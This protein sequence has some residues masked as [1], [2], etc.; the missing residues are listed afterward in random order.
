MDSWT[1]YEIT[2]V[3]M[4]CQFRER[5]QIGFKVEVIRNGK[6]KSATTFPVMLPRKAQT[7]GA[8]LRNALKRARKYCQGER[9]K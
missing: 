9:V 6:L 5:N 2:P 3:F 1:Y 7:G 4:D 8:L